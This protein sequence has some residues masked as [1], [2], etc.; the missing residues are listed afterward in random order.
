MDKILQP[1]NRPVAD[2]RKAPRTAYQRGQSGNPQGRAK[3]TPQ[4]LDLIAACKNKTPRALAVLVEIM[5][6]GQIERNRLA[7]AL[8]ILERGH[9]RPIQ[10]ID[11]H[12]VDERAE[13]TEAQWAKGMDELR[14]AFAARLARPEPKPEPITIEADVDVGDPI[15]PIWAISQE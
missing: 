5:E 15:A 3:R 4:E 13:E 10:P 11:T 1:A 12:H 9:G 14:A 6:N 8:A 7:A 2:K